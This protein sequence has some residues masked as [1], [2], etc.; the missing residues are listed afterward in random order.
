[1]RY[2]PDTTPP[3][4]T[5]RQFLR[6]ALVGGL[7]AAAAAALT[8][9]GG[10]ATPPGA[11][12]TAEAPS[13]AAPAARGTITLTLMY[14]EAEFSKAALDA[15]LA[16]NP[17][18]EIERVE[19]DATGDT[20]KAM[21]ANGAPPD[22]FRINGIEIPPAV[23]RDTLLDLTGYFD[24]SQA[25]RGDDL[26]PANGLYLY[27]GRRYGMVKDW[28]PDHSIFI[29]TAAFEEAGVGIPSDK[30]PLSFQDLADLAPQ[31][32]VREG[33]APRMGWAYEGGWFVRTIQVI[34]AQQGKRLYA[35]D[36]STIELSDSP[37]AVEALKF[38]YDLSKEQ[39]IWNPLNPDP[40]LGG[41]TQGQ[42]AMV[43]YGYWFGNLIST[44]VDS[45]VGETA[46]ML[47][48][49]TWNGTRL[50]PA[51]S[52]T[53]A[54]IAKLSKNPD[55]A[56]KLFEYF[57]AG[58]PAVDRA[59]GGWGVPGLISLYPLMPQDTPLNRQRYA[60]LQDELGHTDYVIEANP[61][62]SDTLFNASW[63]ANLERALKGSIGFEELVANIETEVNQA[64]AAG[65]AG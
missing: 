27:E 19:G 39:V 50:N 55:A 41:F 23:R 34:L 36:L 63:F 10:S 4:L 37:E 11:A 61:Y 24:I 20:F 28:S 12:P 60:V 46:M 5:R 6:A 56:W 49:P 35:P 47:P 16:E 58:P 48:G 65:R 30:E 8:A 52:G 32:T 29:N 45:K 43:T 26:A 44:T 64:L 53:G 21:L 51:I 9:C 7:T 38:Y 40:G 14:G 17:N 3:A 18:I 15:F 33:Q 2:R 25:I 62:Y 54:A 22:V 1:M 42:S 13:A 31:L 59:K 57:M